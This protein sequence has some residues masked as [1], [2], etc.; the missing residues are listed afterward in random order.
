LRPK[1]QRRNFGIGARDFHATAPH[2]HFQLTDG[3]SSLQSE[4]VPFI[5]DKFTHLG[6]G[7]QYETDKHRSM[8]RDHSIP[9][10][11]DV[12]EVAPADK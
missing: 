1:R 10:N 2:P 6:P 3:N 12:V 9:A 4:G 7:S 8:P 11:N 5:F